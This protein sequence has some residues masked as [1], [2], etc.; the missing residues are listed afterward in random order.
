[1]KM[2]R[3]NEEFQKRHLSMTKRASWLAFFKKF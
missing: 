3:K 2:S 1:M